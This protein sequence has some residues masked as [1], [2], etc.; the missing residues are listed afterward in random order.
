[1]HFFSSQKN[2]S[3]NEYDV[4]WE[5]FYKESKPDI[6]VVWMNSEIFTNKDKLTYVSENLRKFIDKSNKVYIYN[7]DSILDQEQIKEQIE[8]LDRLVEESKQLKPQKVLNESKVAE[9]L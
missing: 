8:E 4:R 3:G 7:R 9:E 1:L 2:S 6:V 5:R